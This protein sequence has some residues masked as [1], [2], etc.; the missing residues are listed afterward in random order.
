MT[1]EKKNGAVDPA[2]ATGND[3]ASGQPLEPAGVPGGENDGAE[4]APAE[5]KP[6]NDEL[7]Q[8]RREAEEYYARLVRTQADF[9]NY[10]RRVRSER[11]E[12]NA[13]ASEA[14]IVKFLP[15]IDNLERAIA[16]AAQTNDAKA[17]AEGVQMVLR[18]ILEWLE[19]EGVAPI[20]ALGQEFN[21]YE[22]H[23]VMQVPSSEQ[24][25]NTVVTEIL[26]G[27]KMKEKVIR[28]A[29]VG[30]ARAEE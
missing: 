12:M 15:V 18:Q 4:A 20:E 24:P 27:Y 10:K 11:E 1:E 8:V 3:P 9:E 19:K 2:A 29:M 17:L 16:S 28:P 7:E 30:V 13:F 6:E 22:H 14:L 21:P 25:E 5:A 23:A 26:K